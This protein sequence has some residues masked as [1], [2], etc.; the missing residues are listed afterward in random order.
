MKTFTLKRVLALALTLVIVV[1]CGSTLVS[2]KKDEKH[3]ALETVAMGFTLIVKDSEGKKE[4]LELETDKT[5]LVDALMDEGV[6]KGE[7]TEGG[8]IIESVN[9]IKADKDTPTVIWKLY[10][11]G[12]LST[13]LISS[14]PLIDGNKYT[15]ALEEITDQSPEYT[16]D[17]TETYEP[18]ETPVSADGEEAE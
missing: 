12:E 3:K 18:S 7:K 16:T 14:V 10:I 9:G 2:C 11:N 5:F 1:T 4:K 15:L 17:G 8:Y 6:L 13:D